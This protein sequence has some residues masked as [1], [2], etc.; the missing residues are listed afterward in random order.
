[1]RS[2]DRRADRQRTDDDL[3]EEWLGG[4]C[5]RVRVLRVVRLRFAILNSVSYQLV[6]IITFRG[7]LIV[8]YDGID[9]DRQK[10]RQT[11]RPINGFYI[12][13]LFIEAS[14]IYI[15]AFYNENLAFLFLCL[16]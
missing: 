14:S 12:C 3:V 2:T 1:L 10:D 5:S 6:G 11:E 8:I 4:C 9:A 7:L 15:L 13:C 16:F